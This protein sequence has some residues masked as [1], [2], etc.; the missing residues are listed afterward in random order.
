MKSLGRR[1]LESHLCQIHGASQVFLALDYDGTLAPIVSKPQEARLSLNSLSLLKKLSKNPKIILCIVTGRSMDSILKLI[2][3]PKILFIANHGFEMKWGKKTWTHPLSKKLKP[4]YREILKKLK[5]GLSCFPG[6][7]IENKKAT[8]T[9]HYR[10]VSLQQIPYLKKIVHHILSSHL[11]QI[12]LTSGKKVFEIRPRTNWD[13]G[14]ALLKMGRVKNLSRD[15][16]KIYIGDD[17]T[18][19]DVFRVLKSKSLTVRVG[20][21]KKS[22]A[23]HYVQSP[24]EVLDFL[25][26]IIFPVRSFYRDKVT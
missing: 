6:I 2:P 15:A 19:E 4:L 25:N 11:K 22:Y 26:Q 23:S 16:F 3:L 8:L 20:L 17:Q 14:K 12:K 7:F 10:D 5:R 21:S 9:V 24:K 13:K 1:E 18:D